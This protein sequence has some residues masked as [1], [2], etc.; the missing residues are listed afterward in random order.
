[1]WEEDGQDRRE[2]W[3]DEPAMTW[4][5]V[6]ATAIR[7]HGPQMVAEAVVGEACRALEGLLGQLRTWGGD[8]CR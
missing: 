6:I 7:D 2:A 8:L 4:Q 3:F 5:W 1:M